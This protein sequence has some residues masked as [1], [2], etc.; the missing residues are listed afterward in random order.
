MSEEEERENENHVLVGERPPEWWFTS[1][2]SAPHLGADPRL[3]RERGSDLRNNL[4]QRHVV[5]RE[6]QGAPGWCVPG[7]SWLTG[8]CFPQHPALGR[9]G[10]WELASLRRDSAE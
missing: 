7:P 5:P 1:S 3:S 6:L 8:S 9:L 4:S 10:P 2:S